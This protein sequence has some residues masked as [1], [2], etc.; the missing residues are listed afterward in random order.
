M[1]LLCKEVCGQVEEEKPEDVFQIL[2]ENGNSLGVLATGEARGENIRQMRYLLK[3]WNMNMASFVETQVDW[4]HA[5][6]GHQFDNLFTRG[7][8]RHSVAAYTSAVRRILS[9]RNQRDDTGM[10]ALGRAV[11]RIC[12]VDKTQLS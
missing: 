10:R 12:T 4:R 3:K 5:D 6:E 11:A 2:F 9:P 8:D 7:R 1:F